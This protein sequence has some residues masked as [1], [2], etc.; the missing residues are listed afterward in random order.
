MERFWSKVNKTETCW[1]WS[2]STNSDGYGQFWLDKRM[3]KAHVVAYEILVGSKP[4]GTELDHT[5]RV[6]SC[7]NPKHLEAVTHK[8][9]TLRGISIPAL[10]AAKTH[11]KRGHEFKGLNLY[12]KPSGERVCRE[13]KR[14]YRLGVA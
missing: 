2:A 14:F 11:C 3:V 7:V 6:K 9:N 8:E 10:N 13:C 1:L 4:E 5:C 12:V